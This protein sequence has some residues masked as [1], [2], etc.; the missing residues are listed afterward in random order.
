M[1]SLIL[2]RS[3]R[4]GSGHEKYLVRMAYVSHFPE[5]DASLVRVWFHLRVGMCRR[6]P[7]LP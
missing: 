3:G 5:I 1:P 7:P 6:F 4:E 2:C